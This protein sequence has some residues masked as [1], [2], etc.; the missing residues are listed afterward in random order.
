M[1]LV[2][3]CVVGLLL[4]SLSGC[5]KYLI[6]R[7]DD[8]TAMTTAKVSARVV[9]GIATLGATEAG[10]KQIKQDE[11]LDAHQARVYKSMD[12]SQTKADEMCKQFPADCAQFQEISHRYQQQ[13]L[14][15][16]RAMLNSMIQSNLAIMRMQPVY[17]APVYQAPRS[18][19]CSSHTTG[20][21][22][23]TDCY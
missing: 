10:I 6:V 5:G 17:Q 12:D 19:H 1:K 13:T 9:L 16:Y 20:G 7:D 14:D 21:F 4:M 15:S 22:T 11:A 8:G 3:L 23:N 18:L 2:Q